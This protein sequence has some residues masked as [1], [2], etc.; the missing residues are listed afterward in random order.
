MKQ[1]FLAYTL[2]SLLVLALLSVLSYGYGAGY[3]YVQWRNWQMQTNLWIWLALLA[4]FGLIIQLVWLQL[5]RYLTREQRKTETVLDFK[6][7]HPY[8]QLGVI[9]LLQAEQDQQLFIQRVFSQSGLLRGVIESR[10]FLGNA[11]TDLALKSLNQASPHAFELAELQR[12]EIFLHQQDPEQALTHLEF[13]SQHALSP[14][15]QQVESAYQYRINELWGEFAVQYPWLY[16]RSRKYGH[17]SHDYK[18][19][20]L[21]QLLG[22]FDQATLDDLQALQQRYLDMAGQIQNRTPDIQILWLKLLARMPEMSQQHESLANL[23]LADNF[24]QDVF[25]LWFQQQLLK[26][27]PDYEY[28]EQRILFLENKYPSIPILSFAKWHIYQATDR[29]LEAEQLLELYPDNILMI[30]LRIKTVFKGNEDLIQQLN[31]I[32]ENDAN[33][34]Q[35]KI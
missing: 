1:I 12:I 15:L 30:Y 5:K 22:Q 16:L 4:I 35:L 19:Q 32:F 25:Y 33:F 24:D 26:Q 10:L 9:W 18:E 20:W 34:M 23:L 2:V 6:T 21:Q 7:L 29:A 8:E 13:L 27:Q 17:L 28:V 11:E 31:L 14:W 3:V